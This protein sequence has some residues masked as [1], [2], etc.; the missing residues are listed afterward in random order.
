MVNTLAKAVLISLWLPV[1][2]LAVSVARFGAGFVTAPEEGYATLATQ[3]GIGWLGVIPL[4][5]ALMLLKPLSGLWFGIC[6]VA[7]GI[8][9]VAAFIV[10]GLFGE[11]GVVSSLISLSIPA[12]V[13]YFV[14]RTGKGGGSGG[15]SKAKP[16][17]AAAKPRPSKA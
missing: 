2:V 9:A 13:V 8:L 5:M 14:M 11:A 17:A 12:F 6:A 15:R 4:T 7:L 3:L 10:G 1:L 16:T